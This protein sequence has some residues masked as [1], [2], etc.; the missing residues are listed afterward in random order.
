VFR[1]IYTESNARLQSEASRLG[2]IT[3]LTEEEAQATSDMNDQHLDRPW[4]MW[5]RDA[6]K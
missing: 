2:E 4:E 6:L 1:G 3:F 5:Q